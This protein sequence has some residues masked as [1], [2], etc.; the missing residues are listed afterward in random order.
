MATFR[1]IAASLVVLLWSSAVHAG[2]ANADFHCT[3]AAGAPK[4]TLD[5]DIPG[6][7]A[8]FELRLSSQAATA[9]M[10]DR[11]ERISVV[12]NFAKGVFS[13]AVTKADDRNLLLYALPATVKHSRGPNSEV[14]AHF[15]AV[16]LQAPRPGHVGAATNESTL[17]NIPMT[18]TY[19]HYI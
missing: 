3:S 4:L 6:D 18:C 16:L 2:A 10:T 13:I 11:E 19:V 17:R 8:S 5:G 15:S 12:E 7:F 1:A 14:R 9:T